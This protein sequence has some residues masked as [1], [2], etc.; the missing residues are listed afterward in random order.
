MRW[1]GVAAVALL[2][3]FVA[4]SQP[5]AADD[6]PAW[7]QQLTALRCRQPTEVAA[8]SLDPARLAMTTYCR[9]AQRPHSHQGYESLIAVDE[10]QGALRSVRISAFSSGGLHY[11]RAGG[12]IWFSES[13]Q[14]LVGQEQHFIEAFSLE[15]QSVSERSLG[16]IDV[17]F[18]AGNAI[19]TQGAEC[20]VL[21][22][23]NL[24]DSAADARVFVLS[25]MVIR[26]DRC[27]S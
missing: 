17:P 7:L 20:H 6:E 26:S 13:N 24:N 22:V 2:A 5:T 3:G 1:Y 11:T 27:E 21:R 25:T 19:V 18:V 10:A 23:Q 16:R 12:I 15:P 4:L 14:A 9:R 8:A